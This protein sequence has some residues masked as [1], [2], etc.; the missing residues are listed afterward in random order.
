MNMEHIGTQIIETERLILR[1]LTVSDAQEMYDNWASSELA[2]KYLTWNAYN[3]KEFDSLLD[4]LKS[5]ERYYQSNELYD[6][7]I[8]IKSKDILIG[9]ITFVTVSEY[10][11]AVELGY[12]IGPEWWGNEY[13]V[14]AGHALIDFAFN[15]LGVNRI[16]A[17]HD[18]RNPA[19]GRVIEKL[20]M[21]Y[22]GTHRDYRKLKGEYV[23]Y[24]HYAILASDVPQHNY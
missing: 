21:Q 7:G 4:R 2:T 18:V 9:T 12:V 1:P 17:F 16:E 24:K 22:E 15:R 20:G 23:T 19:S 13:V 10:H 5:M 3:E 14:E 6:W 8:V 11:N